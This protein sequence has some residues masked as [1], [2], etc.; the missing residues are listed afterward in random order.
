MKYEDY[1][2][3]VID[4]EQVYRCTNCGWTGTTV[5]M[6]SCFD[7]GDEYDAIHSKYCCPSCLAFHLFI[8]NWEKV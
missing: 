3:Y 7:C 5:E 4:T 8:D 6:D 2:G 1:Y